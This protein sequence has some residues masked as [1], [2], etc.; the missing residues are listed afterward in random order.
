MILTEWQRDS[1]RVAALRPR[2]GPH[3]PMSTTGSLATEPTPAGP[4]I[5][6]CREQLHAELGEVLA[7]RRPGRESADEIIVLNPMG[8]A[9]ADIACAAEVYT[10]AC[11]QQVGTWLDLY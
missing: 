7:G 4:R 11:A 8:I 10:R 3:C 2:C 9:V 1:D 6:C 5:L